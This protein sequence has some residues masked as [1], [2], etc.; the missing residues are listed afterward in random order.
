V[1][2]DQKQ[3]QNVDASNGKDRSVMKLRNKHFALLKAESQR[4]MQWLD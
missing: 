2:S 1:R 4:L 3:A